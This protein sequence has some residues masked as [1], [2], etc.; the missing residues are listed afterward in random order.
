MST[1]PQPARK[2]QP[3]VPFSLAARPMA[4]PF[5]QEAEEATVG[6]CL[7]DGELYANI[8]AFLG[9]DDFFLLRHEYLWEAMQ[10]V[11]E[12]GEPVDYLTV[13]RELEVQGRLSDVGGPAYLTQLLGRTPVTEHAEVYGR[14]V[15]RAAIRRRLVAASDDIR[16]LALDETVALEKVKD[17]ALETV[18]RAMARPPDRHADTL[19]ALVT[20]YWDE[21]EQLVGSEKP[22]GIPTGLKAL[23]D[24]L[25]G[26]ARGELTVLAAPP[27]AGKTSLL[28]TVAWNAAKLG[29]RVALF[30]AEMTSDQIVRRLVSLETGIPTGILK[31]GPL[32]QG[33]F[34]R[35][36]EASARISNLPL[37][38]IDEFRSP[39]PLQLQRRLRGLVKD[40]G[41]D[42]VIVDGLYRMKTQRPLKDAD[43]KTELLYVMEDMDS[44]AKQFNLPVFMT[45]QFNRDA[46]KGNNKRPTL[47]NLKDSSAV[48]EIAQVV[49]GMYRE[50]YYTRGPVD[51]TEVIV[52][53]NRDGDYGTAKLAFHKAYGRYDDLPGA[54]K[55]AAR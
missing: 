13:L 36:V 25:G 42:L 21:I 35:F 5:S 12:R 37:R 18:Y 9:A 45:H 40:M 1:N 48:E 51:T 8:A 46:G 4:V 49:L 41:V 32:T 27:G 22:F 6:A 30:S 39:T 54:L 7:R 10:S 55:W 34:S 15:E 26:F 19:G 17:G 53:K 2:V 52:L 20:K 14:I 3:A 28:V 43:R 47:S 29:A 16:S 11:F 23:D 50:S 38:V 31:T 33:M 24:V 44:L